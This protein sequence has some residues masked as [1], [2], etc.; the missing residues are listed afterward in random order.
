[1]VALSRALALVLFV[2]GC[3]TPGCGARPEEMSREAIEAELYASDSVVTYADGATAIGAFFEGEHRFGIRYDALPL[4]WQMAIVAAEDSK[5]WSHNGVDP[6]GI[7]RATRDNI[8]AGGVVSGGSTLT[9]QTA[10]NLF[11]RPGRTLAAKW[12]ELDYAL[13]LEKEFTKQDILTFYANLFHVTGNGAGL[14]V[15]ARY[16]FD[17]PVAEL[18]LLESAFLAGLV[19]GP[20]NYDPFLGDQERQAQARQ[21]AHDRTRYVLGRLAEEDLD[22]LTPPGVEASQAEAV[23]A[24]AEALLADGFE[25]PFRRGRFRHPASTVLDEVERRLQAPAIQDL[26]VQA[27]VDEVAGAGLT[28][29]TTLQDGVQ[30]E[31]TYGLA[32]HL[33]VLGTQLEALPAS[34]FVV[35]DKYAPDHDPYDLPVVHQLRYG[36]VVRHVDG[37]LQLDLGGFDCLV[38]RDAVVRAAAAVY[39]GQKKDRWTKVPTAEVDGFVAGIEDGSVVWVSIRDDEPGEER[40][41]LEVRPEVQG[42]VVVVEDGRI[43]A[44]IGGNPNRDFDRVRALRQFGST[45]K[46]LVYH[47]AMTL[48]WRPDDLLHNTPT[49]FAFSGSTY[50]PR[51]DHEPEPE[52][53]MA[54]AGVKSENIASVWLLYH[55]VDQLSARE[56]AVIADKVGL[57]KKPDESAREYRTRVQEAGVLPTKRDLP[58]ITF[59]AARAELAGTLKEQGRVEEARAIRAASDGRSFEPLQAKI[60]KCRNQYEA[61]ERGLK[62]GED[63]GRRVKDLLYLEE[64]GDIELACAF[65]ADGFEPVSK[66]FEQA[67]DQAQ[68]SSEPS[69]KSGKRRR[70]RRRKPLSINLGFGKSN[71]LRKKARNLVSV[72]EVLMTEVLTLGAVDALGSAMERQKLAIESGEGGLYN[73]DVLLW[74]P[75]FRVV[76]AMRYVTDL[77]ASLGVQTELKEVLSLP[78]GATEITLEEATVLYGGLVSGKTAS[79][80]DPE[81]GPAVLIAEIRTSD[82]KVLYRAEPEPAEV[83]N[84]RVGDM[85]A[86]ILRNVVQY[87]TGRA[88]KGAVEVAGADVPLGGKTGTT[89]DFRNAAFLGFLPGPQGRGYRAAAGHA[90]GV[91]VGYDDNRSMS[92]GNLR[93]SGATGA[94]PPWIATVQGIQR[95]ADAEP[96]GLPRGEQWPLVHAD[97]LREI[98]IEE[99]ATALTMLERDPGLVPP[100]T[101][102]TSWSTRAERAIRRREGERT[103][104]RRPQK[105]PW[106]KVW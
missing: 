51:P 84:P 10:K 28:I 57:A 37:Q 11:E 61:L 92:V 102:V 71:P 18:G 76:L 46:P 95:F 80:E 100:E 42:A 49:T 88:A 81:L 63:P 14:G 34:A 40:C 98:P 68:S 44:R 43:R 39:R 20:A 65:R 52:V 6:G 74:H 79:V 53:S 69:G 22:A 27:G 62:D 35:D 16:F 94:L 64:D 75:D 33:S 41:D 50:Q 45:F 26:L 9:Q 86:D 7:A 55:L 23:R 87:G 77:A 47:A 78:L 17:K 21:R 36:R 104:V 4:A 83:T 70:R 24:E 82:G 89:N 105:D 30:H 60:G 1:M 72:D 106:W 101:S 31:A 5:F 90:V 8:G 56:L 91:Y 93:V 19:K 12:Q 99:G 48:G 85:T 96:S 15:A 58:G 97:G 3:N 66:L 13:H 38:D 2:A 67:E 59:A 73:P 54:W 32:H 103:R 25:L 29:V